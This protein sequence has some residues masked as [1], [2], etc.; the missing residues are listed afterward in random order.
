MLHLQIKKFYFVLLYLFTYLP[1]QPPFYAEDV[2]HMYSKIMKSELK[3]PKNIAP[4]AV[5][6]M[7]GV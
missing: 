3:F 6:L 5:S 1:N 2:E 4:E 7:E